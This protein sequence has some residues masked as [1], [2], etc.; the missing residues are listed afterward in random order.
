MAAVVKVTVDIEGAGENKQ[1][2]AVF[3]LFEYWLL[4]FA[5]IELFNVAMIVHVVLKTSAFAVG[6]FL[7]FA[8]ALV[9]LAAAAAVANVIVVVAAASPGC[10]VP[11]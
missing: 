3:I 5:G 7:F 6:N 10:D 2:F 9:A 11:S 8:K 1:R 4:L